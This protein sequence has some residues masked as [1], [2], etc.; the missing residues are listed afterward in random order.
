MKVKG[1]HEIFCCGARV[2]ISERGVEVLSEPLVKHCPL[3]EALYGTG[4]ID[5]EAVRRSVE[6]KIAGHGFCCGSRVFDGGQVVAFGASEMM[7]VWLDKRLVDC[8]VVV[9][10]GAGT[11]V[12]S[13]GGLVQAIG[14]RLT[15][16]ARTSPIREVIEYIEVEGGTVLDKACARIDQVE[17]VRRAFESGFR[18]VAV[19]VAGFQAEAIS[20]IRDVGGDVVIFSVCNTCV[21]NIDVEHIAKADVVCTSASTILR[22]EVGNE[23][24]LQ[25]GVTIPVYALTERGK[26][27]VLAYLVE[28]N[29]KLV[30]FKISKLPYEIKDKGP[31]LKL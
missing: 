22:S 23:A 19:S 20:L 9:C 4:T 31:K 28:F 8:A 29:K 11:V 18:R 6:M 21:R 15:G 26:K 17:G 14:A 13:N 24:L 16:I 27:L 2:K 5:R 3:H 7:H 25:V 30:V 1:E 10:E 12:T